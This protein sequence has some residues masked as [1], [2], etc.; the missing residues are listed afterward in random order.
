MQQ[1]RV[2][3]AIIGAGTIAQT[4]AAVIAKSPD[5]ILSAIVD[6]NDAGRNL[7]DKYHAKFFGSIEDMLKWRSQLSIDAAI[8]WSIGTV[9]GVSG[10]WAS[11][12]PPEYFQGNGKWRGGLD[13]GVI[14]IN[15]IHEVD[16]LQYLI[17]PIQRV[18][19]EKAL[20]I[21]SHEAEEGLSLTLR[22]QSGVVGTFLAL[23]NVASPFNIEAGTGENQELYPFSGQDCYRIFGTSGT[24]SIPDNKLWSYTEPK[25]GR[26]SLPW[27]YIRLDSQDLEDLA[28]L[29]KSDDFLGAAVTMPNKIRVIPYLDELS[30]DA[31]RLGCINTIY[32][33]KSLNGKGRGSLVGTNTDW[34]GIKNALR[35][36]EAA[37]VQSLQ[38]RPA[39]VIGGGATSRAAIYAL[40]KGF[41]VPEVFLVNRD[42]TEVEMTIKDLKARGMSESLIH[43]RT[44][45]DVHEMLHGMTP[46]VIIATIPDSPPQSESEKLLRAIALRLIEMHSR[47]SQV[48]P[49]IFLEMTYTPSPWTQLAKTAADADW[50]IVTGVDVMELQAVEQS[51]IWTG[52]N[53]DN[54]PYAEASKAMRSSIVMDKRDKIM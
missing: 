52:R 4:H 37:L 44:V 2:A 47:N 24:L 6:T 23:D 46:A 15:L 54:L 13:G 20:S 22:F 32:V 27:R 42:P 10:V 14:L 50:K 45:E 7:A 36:H 9:I 41:N 3:I 19:A 16:L 18:Y 48:K 11:L 34:I 33:K 38:D 8:V 1:D 26:N 12:K 28:W 53:I 29:M 40:V 5:A 21:R 31:R 30:D 43:L 17:G 49:G 39:V 25:K 51:V 35:N